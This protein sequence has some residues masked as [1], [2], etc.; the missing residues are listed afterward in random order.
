[1]TLRKSMEEKHTKD[2]LG[3]LLRWSLQERVADASPSPEVWEEILARAERSAGWRRSS[4][5]RGYRAARGQLA[6]VN[7]FLVAQIVAWMWPQGRWVDW[8]FDPRFARTLFDQYGFFLFRL[9]F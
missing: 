8:K 9:A 3:S 7:A 1:M 2:E 6:R 4:F 5:Y